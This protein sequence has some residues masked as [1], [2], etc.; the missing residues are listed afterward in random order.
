MPDTT[1]LV[2]KYGGGECAYRV[3]SGFAHRSAWV[4]GTLS[5]RQNQV[6]TPALPGAQGI[7]VVADWRWTLRMT[8]LSAEFTRKA[9][10]EVEAYFGGPAANL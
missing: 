5:T 2:D 7:Q 4:T 1:R 8:A 6:D 3:M 9:V 10:G